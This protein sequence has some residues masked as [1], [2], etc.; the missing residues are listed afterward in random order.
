MEFYF[1]STSLL[2]P[3]NQSLFSLSRLPGLRFQQEEQL[4]Q[5]AHFSLGLECCFFLFLMEPLRCQ[6]ENTTVLPDLLQNVEVLFH[7]SFMKKILSTTSPRGFVCT[8]AISMGFIDEAFLVFCCLFVEIQSKQHKASMYVLAK[9]VIGC[10]TAFVLSLAT[11][12]RGWCICNSVNLPSAVFSFVLS[13]RLNTGPTHNRGHVT[14]TSELG[15]LCSA[16]R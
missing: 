6:H 9:H 15:H 16:K 5:N 14:L 2:T 8:K 12:F 10:F 7:V 1:R 3:P 11:L 13:L 4:C